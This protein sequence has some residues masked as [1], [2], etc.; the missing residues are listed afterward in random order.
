MR[1]KPD[2]RGLLHIAKINLT[3]AK[4]NIKENDETYV[5]FAMFNTSQ[6][7]EKIMKFLCS[8]YDIDYDYS[9]FLPS[10]ASKLM[11]KDVKIP[12]LVQDSLKEYGEWATKSRYTANQLAM[13]SYVEKHIDCADEWLIAVEKQ[14]GFAIKITGI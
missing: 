12:Q 13:R 4:R 9:H 11:E 5:N 2:D 1:K 7:I 8:C 14:M 10:I 3:E 6:A